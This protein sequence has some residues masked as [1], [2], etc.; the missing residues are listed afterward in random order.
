VLT[1]PFLRRASRA[2]AVPAVACLTVGALAAPAAAA[3]PDSSSSVRSGDRAFV[4]WTEQDPDD[5]LGLPGNTHVGNLYVEDGAYGTWVF[6]EILD[7][8]CGPGQTPDGGHG[9]PGSCEHVGVR[10]LHGESVDL[11]T[12]GQT[13]RLTGTLVVS[14]GGHG[15]PD[16]VIAL[17]PADITW[18]ASAGLSRY[19]GTNTYTD[20][21]VSYRSRVTGLRSDVAR[22]VVTGTLGRMGFAD[23]ADD[24]ARGSFETYTE[25][26]RERMR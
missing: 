17:V 9:G 19:R 10:F 7:L 1:R 13:A 18:T 15:G 11:V 26:S 5:V 14:N 23:D 3:R 6:G 12:S 20:A 24:V 8:E 16:D 25:Q 22:T 2:L 21:N 4:S